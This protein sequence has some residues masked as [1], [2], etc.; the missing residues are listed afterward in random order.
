VVTSSA[1]HLKYQRFCL[2][3]H[4]LSLFVFHLQSIH[5]SSYPCATLDIEA[6]NFSLIK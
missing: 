2:I 4:D 3:T 6:N 1:N 5:L